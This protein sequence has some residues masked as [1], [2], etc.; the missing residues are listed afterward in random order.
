ME[1]S[2]RRELDKGETV[3]L[4]SGLRVLEN[5]Y[6]KRDLEVQLREAQKQL[7]ALKKQMDRAK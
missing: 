5:C 6:S 4:M 1:A 7:V 3:A 2:V